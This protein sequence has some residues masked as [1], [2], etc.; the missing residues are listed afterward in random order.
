MVGPAGISRPTIPAKT[1][2][3]ALPRIF[4]PTTESPTLS[5]AHAIIAHIVARSGAN[6]AEQPLAGP[7]EVHGALI[8]AGPAIIRPHGPA[9][10]RPPL[11]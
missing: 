11:P 10:R 4:G 5:T 1:R 2:S 9:I 3:V 6:C 8:G 7:L